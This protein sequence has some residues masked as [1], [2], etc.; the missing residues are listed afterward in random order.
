MLLSFRWKKK[1]KV[2]VKRFCLFEA[3][4]FFNRKSQLSSCNRDWFCADHVSIMETIFIRMSSFS[5]SWFFRGFRR[6]RFL[7]SWS[8]IFN[9][10]IAQSDAAVEKNLFA[11]VVFLSHEQEGIHLEAGR[12]F[13]AIWEDFQRFVFVELRVEATAIL[14][15]FEESWVIRVRAR[16][17]WEIKSSLIRDCY[18]FIPRWPAKKSVVKIHHNI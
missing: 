2:F 7:T 18:H 1:K 12:C 14:D 4:G 5:L 15:E 8:A 3:N 10:W 16:K 6:S 9:V 11:S 17:W 13:L